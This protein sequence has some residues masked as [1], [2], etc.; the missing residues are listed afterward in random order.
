MLNKGKAM[1][2]LTLICL[3]LAQGCRKENVNLIAPEDLPKRQFITEST[4]Q[5]WID[6]NPTAK[7]LTLDWSKAK[8]ANIRGKQVV[9]I[10]TL[11]NDNITG[12]LNKG[13]QNVSNQ[14]L[15][16]K[17]NVTVPRKPGSN[18]N[19]DTQHPP[20]VFFIQDSGNGKLHAYLLNFISENKGDNNNDK[21]NGKLYEWNLKGDTIFVQQVKN[22]VLQESYCMKLAQEPPVESL[23]LTLKNGKLQSQNGLKDKTAV[24]FWK[25]IANLA[26]NVIGW[27]GHIFGLSVYSENFNEGAG[28]WRLNINWGSIFGSG[29]GSNSTS[30]YLASGWPIYNAY[31]PGVY[32]QGMD[33]VAD[34]AGQPNPGDSGNPDATSLDGSFEPYP[35]SHGPNVTVNTLTADYVITNLGIGTQ[36]QQ[37]FLRD[38]NNVEITAAL[39]DYI[40]KLQIITQDNIEFGQWAVGYLMANPG[41]FENFKNQ[42]LPATEIIADPDADNWIDSDNEVLFD[43]DQTAYQEYQDTDPWPTVDRVISFEKFVPMRQI[44]GPDGNPKN[45]NCLILA[46]EQLGKAGYTCSGFLPGGQTF[47]IYTTQDGVNLTQTKKAI[48]YM[49]TSLSKKIP[50]LIGVDNRAGAPIANKDNSTDHYVVVVAMGTDEKG[51]YFQFMDSATNNPATGASYSNRLYFNPSTGKITGRTAIIGYRSQAGMRDY[52]VTQIRKS[53]KK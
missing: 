13:E 36:A 16:P 26:N 53:I 17:N 6:D 50:V 28:G 21:R 12:S 51:K 35:N 42:F 41:S 47:S 38:P 45:V 27:I 32:Y 4:I 49:I 10:P 44:I 2:C 31:M 9:R 18:I 25:W 33:I 43:P 5:H 23:A 24:D 3:F 40:D 29:G 19:Y 37:S 11:N 46:K 22:N 39:A 34:Q 30:G 1:A 15:K 48:S 52:T 8:Q 7:L 14:S 20:E